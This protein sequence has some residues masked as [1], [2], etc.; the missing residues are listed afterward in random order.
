METVWLEADYLDSGSYDSWLAMWTSGARYIVPIEPGETDFENT[1]NY[2]YDDHTMRQKR[3]ERLL[4]GRS[5][6]A[7]PVARTIRLL[8][9]FRLLKSDETGCEIRCAQLLTE[10]RRGR[11]RT[12][13]ADVTYRLVRGGTGLL[14]DQKVI[15]LI[16]A[17]ESLQGISYI[18]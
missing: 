9:R 13:T 7:S 16:N 6:S 3:V 17:T 18:L 2:A 5:V 4:S 14:I 10:F 8:S 1:L 15:R 11:E 12:Y